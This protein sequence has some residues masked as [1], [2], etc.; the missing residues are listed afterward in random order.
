MVD[1]IKWF[2]DIS[3]GDVEIV[4][5]KGANLGEMTNAGLPIPPGFVV[6]LIRRG[7]VLSTER[8]LE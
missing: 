8:T 6:A 3:K 7:M 1:R 2:K 5:G 4:G